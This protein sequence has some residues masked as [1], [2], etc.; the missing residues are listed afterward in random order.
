M[1]TILKK[2]MRILNATLGLVMIGQGVLPLA[3][4][5]LAADSTYK[6]IFSQKHVDNNGKLLKGS[7]YTVTQTQGKY[8]PTTG[9][10]EDPTLQS[11]T[12]I[13]NSNATQTL[14][15]G[16]TL[17]ET[18]D[19][20]YELQLP[21]GTYEFKE[22][23]AVTGYYKERDTIRVH[24]PATN[25]D[26][27][28]FLDNVVVTPKLNPILKK[29]T[30]TKH[31]NEA[32]GDKVVGAKFKLY[33]TTDL[34]S[35]DSTAQYE[36]YTEGADQDGKYTTGAEGTL[37]VENL[38]YGKYYFEETDAPDTHVLSQEKIR[39]SVTEESED[40]Q[41]ENLNLTAE[42][43]N[44]TKPDVDKEITDH[45]DATPANPVIKNN[46]D[47]VDYT[48]K[49]TIPY[50]IESYKEF[51]VTDT[52]DAKLTFKTDSLKVNNE[53]ADKYFTLATENNTNNGDVEKFTLTATGDQLK[54]LAKLKGQQIK[55]TYQSQV[56]T[57][58]P[59]GSIISNRAT[60][61]YKNQ[62]NQGGKI[63]N[64]KDTPPSVKV[65]SNSI[66]VLKKDG[67]TQALLS[68]V[69]FKLYKGTVAPENLVGDEKTTVDGVATWEN[70]VNGTYQLV[71]TGVP[72]AQGEEQGYRLLNK[73]I[74][75]ILNNQ[76]GTNFVLE[77]DVLNYK[78]NV[79]IPNTGTMGALGY[80]AVGTGLLIMTK[81]KREDEQEKA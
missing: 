58:T 15:Q 68:G 17:T 40:G 59:A 33:R 21:E 9:A 12:V 73:P 1:E 20:V 45:A 32:T 62:W 39:F 76:Q 28:G 66:K 24:L 29:V 34:T 14:P 5:A 67:T 41:N 6:V 42:T 22:T 49:I 10:F 8:N 46:G 60:L 81:L 4:T 65:A 57:D 16:V 7:E 71:E 2:P 56:D 72:T 50:D 70:L 78:Q 44:Y 3:T 51:V 53:A 18:S 43:V 31:S 54:E 74:E 37:S 52:M 75:I 63:E 38:P 19:G 27:N 13:L 61:D 11:F 55:V 36:A 35:P 26:G 77:K 79:F 30:L 64:K 69:K 25:P 47:L 23:K 80:I 48:M